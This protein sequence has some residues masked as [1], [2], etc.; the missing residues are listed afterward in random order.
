MNI[1]TSLSSL[2][3]N[4]TSTFPPVSNGNSSQQEP[5][6]NGSFSSGS[7]NMGNTETIT[8]LQRYL[9]LYGYIFLFLFRYFGHINTILI[10][11]RQTLLSV[12]TSS[13][14]ICITI[15]N[16]IYLLVCIYDFLY[17]GIGLT[18]VNSETNSN[19]SNALCRFRLF[20]QSA[21]MCSSAWVL[22]ILTID[23]F[24]RLRAQQQQRQRLNQG[25]RRAFVDRQMLIIMLT[26]I[27][28]FFSTQIPL[29]LFN[30]L[31][32]SVLQSRL[33]QTQALQLTSILNF[34]ASINYAVRIHRYLFH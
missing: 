5:P 14:F 29:S 9:S 1:A 33:S 10:F 30:I 18:P 27:F 17:I 7:N 12:S 2:N 32:P 16:I 3:D 26:S 4:Y 31:L 21:A 8:D 11:L 6:P 34:V 23:I 13:L 20:I 28:L 25:L 22:L 15:S 19:L 24:L